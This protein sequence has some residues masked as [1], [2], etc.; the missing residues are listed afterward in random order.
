MVEI[1]KKFQTYLPR[2]ANGDFDPQL[3]AGD[4]LSIE[5]AVN[6]ISSVANGYTPEDRLDGLNLQL[7]TGMPV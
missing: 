1:W 4:Q 3:V 2:Q 6:I 7:G 5:E